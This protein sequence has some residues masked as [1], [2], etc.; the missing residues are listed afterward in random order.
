MEH[1]KPMDLPTVYYDKTSE[2]YIGYLPALMVG[3]P[4]DR[5]SMKSTPTGG[6]ALHHTDTNKLINKSFNQSSFAPLKNKT[7]SKNNISREPGNI[8][9]KLP[10]YVSTRAWNLFTKH[11]HSVGIPIDVTGQDDNFSVLSLYCEFEQV[12]VIEQSIKNGWSYLRAL[13][14]DDSKAEHQDGFTG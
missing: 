6:A 10:G 7:E 11:H 1:R 9:W 8:S 2:Y 12:K 14:S 4:S 5:R 13:E 3:R